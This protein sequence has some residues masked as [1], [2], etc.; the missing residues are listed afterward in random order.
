MGTSTRRWFMVTAFAGWVA[1]RAAARYREPQVYVIAIGVSMYDFGFASLD[2]AGSDA[3]RVA[4]ALQSLDTASNR[5]QVTSLSSNLVRLKSVLDALDDVAVGTVPGD[6]LVFYFAGHGSRRNGKDYLLLS[7]TKPDAYETTALSIDMLG[8]KLA[9]CKATERLLILDAC[10]DSSRA[11]GQVGFKDG[12]LDWGF[13]DRLRAL[14]RKAPS[15]LAIRSAVLC[16]CK[17][18]QRA[19]ESDKDRAG[20]FTSRLESALSSAKADKSVTVKAL[21]DRIA[22]SMPV[23]LRGVQEPDIAG[24]GT[25]TIPVTNLIGS[26]RLMDY[27]NLKA[28]IE[29]L[30][31][32]P[33]GA[34]HMGS[35]N[36]DE[37]E[38]PVHSVTLSAFRMGMTP[39]S[40][41]VWR[42]YCAASGTK[43]PRAP[44]WGLLDDHPVVN[45]SWNEIMGVDGKSGFCAWASDVA[46]FR[47]TLPT[48]AQFEYAALGGQSG[49][50]F[51]WGNSFDRSKLWCS[52]EVIGDA[53]KTAPVV[54]PSNVYRNV[55][56]LTDMAGN[57][58]Q[59]C[60]DW[61]GP[62][63]SA[64]E[65]DPTGPSSSSDNRRCVRGGS[66]HFNYPVL[67]RCAFRDWNF[68][69]IG[70][71]NIGFR[72]SAGPA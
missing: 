72:L 7:D 57:V 13:R 37:A 48:E 19:K 23:E 54:R 67:F 56:G 15:G 9:K 36:R 35:S 18:G 2:Y 34:F 16:A 14:A 24:D 38:E 43:L 5:Y 31:S 25:I 8:D 66:W 46:G 52:R 40:V 21:Y 42:E 69:H 68:P 27:R 11:D 53:D 44:S 60:S 20:V 65:T 58:C 17:P 41:A 1:V 61:S 51:P 71:L 50:E 6:M 12:K 62:Y 28:Y 45:V 33:A 29:S 63:G 55:F 59:W 26:P 70:N 3:L 47:L 32:I 22:D 49:L 30:R 10:R 39:V 4:T 64:S